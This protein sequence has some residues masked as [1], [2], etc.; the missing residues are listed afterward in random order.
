MIGN[1]V[2]TEKVFDVPG[3]YQLIPHAL[4][5]GNYPIIQGIVL[6]TTVF[7]VVANGVVDIALAAIDP[8][9]RVG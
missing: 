5:V 4:D 9:V 6:V 8:R 7:V 2:L 3:V 1:V